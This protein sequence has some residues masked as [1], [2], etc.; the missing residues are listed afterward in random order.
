MPRRQLSRRRQRQGPANPSTGYV[1]QAKDF[2]PVLAQQ[3]EAQRVA[4]IQ[5]PHRAK[6][7]LG[8]P[9][10]DGQAFVEVAVRPGG[11]FA[12]KLLSITAGAITAA[13]TVLLW[14]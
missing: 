6:Q 12:A 2:A 1:W 7:A 14:Q 5:P 9:I 13:R 4:S 10:L 11:G 3:G 8:R